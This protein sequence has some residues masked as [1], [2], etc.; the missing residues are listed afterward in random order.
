MHQRRGLNGTEE[1]IR[2]VAL[3]LFA[4][5]GFQATGIRE[6]ASEAGFTVSALYYY[7][8]TKEELLLDILRDT[9]ISMLTSALRIQEATAT[10]DQKLALLVLLHV[11]FNGEHA[12]QM[13]VANTEL[14]SLRGEA[15]QLVLDLRDR[16]DAVWRE[17]IAQGSAM[18]IF[19]VENAK[20]AAIAL[21]EMCSGVSYWF[22]SN[23]ELTLTQ[24]CYM[25]ADWALGLVRAVRDGKPVRAADLEIVDPKELY[26]PHIAPAS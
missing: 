10:P 15:R 21:I 3:R 22:R 23:G 18:G 6:I 12:Q 5:Q 13:Q 9:A 17:V 2:D 1:R 19:Q 11:W 25:H 20:L 8:G 26:L 14:R 16:Y 4:R 24:V 7:V